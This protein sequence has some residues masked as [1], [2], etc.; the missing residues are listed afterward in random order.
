M[1]TIEE[2]NEKIKKGKV[3]V[4]TAEEMIDITRK[5]GTKKAARYVDVVT[6][7]TRGLMSGTFAVLSFP[8]ASRGTFERAVSAT[9]NGVSAVVGPCPNE[10]LGILDL[11]V[12]GH[13]M[14]GPERK[15]GAGH[16][17]RDMV[18]EKKL[19][20]EFT[21]NQGAE[22]SSE[23]TI[24]DM[25]TAKLVATRHAFRNYVALTNPGRESVKTIFH[26]SEFKP[27]MAELTFSGC[28]QLNPIQNDP[29]LKTIG[30][31]T[32]ILVN[33]AI[34]Y[35]TGLGT[36]SSV[37]SPNLMMTADM[38]GMRADYMGGFATSAGPECSVSWAVP[39]PVIDDSIREAISKLDREIPMPIVDI[40]DRLPI[41]L[42]DYGQ[43][44]DNV[45][46][47]VRVETN[48]CENCRECDAEKKCPTE[49]IHFSGGVP[50]IDR[51]KCFNCGFC[52]TLC[53][54][55]VF[56]GRLG[57]VNFSAFGSQW[58]VPVVC[59]QSDRV[60]ALK[61]AGELKKRLLEGTFKLTEM[62]ERLS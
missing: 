58:K 5:K 61:I 4:V 15:Y 20:V 21:T 6:T 31:G 37:Q 8:V 32:S 39:I 35:V 43:V 27:N 14:G 50:S 60:R 44:W 33:G 2:I 51:K 29:Q 9:I 59:R 26:P 55:K 56:K 10:R 48:A 24:N 30:F 18:E 47:A 11:I 22:L 62:L 19:L 1:K 57:E 52:T 16:L 45:D 28:G 54:R 3:V 13:S 12:L 23:V 7:G 34:G 49:A 41:G 40:K 42:A 38:K 25:Q 53:E 17:F 46:L 36:R